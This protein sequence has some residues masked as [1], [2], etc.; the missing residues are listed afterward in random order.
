MIFGIPN[1]FAIEADLIELHGKWIF[2]KL[3]FYI[4]GIPIGDFEDASDLATSARWGRTFLQ[5]S[6]RR[7]RPDLDNWSTNDVFE[8][9]FGRFVISVFGVLDSQTEISQRE[10]VTEEFVRDPYLLDDIG[11]SSLRDKYTILVVRRANNTDRVLIK[12]YDDDS[13][14][15]VII[16]A[17]F[18]DCTIGRYCTWVEELDKRTC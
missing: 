10:F 13:L 14:R 8:L 2:G 4:N 9:L 1:Y 11:E 3:R 16:A 6:S 15:E 12:S 5:A 7:T 17:D 18:I